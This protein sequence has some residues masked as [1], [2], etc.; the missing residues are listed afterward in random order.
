MLH[1]EKQ[2]FDEVQVYGDIKESD[3]HHNYYGKHFHQLKTIVLQKYAQ[4]VC[5]VLVELHIK[6]L[7]GGFGVR[8]SAICCFSL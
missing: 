4:H 6:G 3:I 7:T 1:H 5:E 2:L 8:F